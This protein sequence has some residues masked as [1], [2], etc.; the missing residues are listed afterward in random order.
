MNYVKHIAATPME[1]C[2]GTRTTSLW[3]LWAIFSGRA[4]ALAL[5][6]A[7]LIVPLAVHAQSLPAAPTGLTATP[8]D[9]QVALSWANPGD[10]TITGY[11]V[12]I[13][14]G[15]N[16]DPIS[17]SDLIIDSDANTI[18]HT[19]E[20]LT[21]GASYTFAVRAV[22]V[23]G[24]GD[25]A[26]VTATPLFAA[27]R[28]LGAANG[29]KQVT[30]SWDNPNNSSISGYEV[31]IANGDYSTISG[32]DA[33]TVEHIVTGLANDT[34]YTLY[35]RAV[36]G[37]AA[38]VWATPTVT[39]DTVPAATTGLTAT[40][41][42]GQVTLIW[43]DPG[44][45][46]ITGYQYSL[47]G[48]TRF[49]VAYHRNVIIDNVA[50]TISHIVRGLTGGTAYSFA[51]RAVNEAGTGAWSDPPVSETPLFKAP[52]NLGAT[53]GDSQVM[54]RWDEADNDNISVYQVSSNGGSSYDSI[55]GSDAT[56]D[57]HTVT[58]LANLT[59]YTFAVRA[60]NSV[61]GVAAMVSATPRVTNVAVPAAPTNLEA[62]A[63]DMKAELTWDDPGNSSISGY[64]LSIDGGANYSDI[65][66]SNDETVKYEVTGLTNWTTYYFALRAVTEG[67]TGAP[68]T[69]SA[70]PGYKPTSAPGSFT[71]NPLHERVELSWT[72]PA[73]GTPI[74]GYKLGK[75]L[76]IETEWSNLGHTPGWLYH[77]ALRLNNHRTYDFSVWAYNQFGN[78]PAST[79]TTIR[80]VGKVPEQPT[81]FIVKRV[82]DAEVEFEW[83]TPAD[84][85]EN[86]RGYRLSLFEGADHYYIDARDDTI[87]TVRT[88]INGTEYNFSLQAENSAGYSVPTGRTGPKTPLFTAPTGLE[89]SAGAGQVT[90]SWTNAAMIRH[91]LR[92]GTFSG[93]EVSSDGGA[94]YSLIDDS[95]DYNDDFGSGYFATTTSH[96][97]ENLTGGTQYTFAVR[98]VNGVSSATAT[99]TPRFAAP[100]NLS[101]TVGNGQ[102][103]LQWDD[104]GNSNISGYQVSS[105]AGTN[106]SPIS[107]SDDETTEYTV[108]G[109]ANDTAYTFAVRA[110]NAS[111][112]GAAATVSATPTVASVEEVPDAPTN[113]QASPADGRVTLSWTD[114]CISSISGY[115]VSSD[116]GTSYSLIDG[117][118]T[119][120]TS[121]TVTGLTNGTS[122][123]FKVRARNEVGTGEPATATATPLIAAPTSFEAAVGYGQVTLSWTD[124]VNPDINRYQVSI[125]GGTSYR[126]ILRSGA[127]TTEHTVTG[128][129]GGA[130]YS[131]AVRA[132]NGESSALVTA[133]PLFVEPPGLQLFAGEGQMT[134]TWLDPGNNNISGYEFSSDGTEFTRIVGSNASTTSHTVTE[135]ENGTVYI[136]WL[137]AVNTSVTGAASE[138]TSRTPRF[139]WPMNLGATV[140]DGQVTL[141][142]DDPD[143]TDISGYEVVSSAE[144]IRIDVAVFEHIDGSS[145]TTV[146]HTVTDLTNDTDL[147]NGTEYFFAVRAVNGR[148]AFVSATPMVT[149]VEDVPEALTMRE[150]T[151][152][153]GQVTLSWDD[154]GDSSISGYQVSRIGWA[155]FRSVGVPAGDTSYTE[156]DLTNGTSYTFL[157]RAVNERG[158]GEPAVAPATTP[159]FAAL[160]GL[161]AAAGYGQ[162][163]L[164]WTNPDNGNISRYELSIDGGI[165]YSLILGSGV[166][167]TSHTV[168]GLTGGTQYTFAVRALNGESSA[169][170]T[171]TPL[172]AAPANLG[173][174][175]GYEQVTL[176]WDDPGNDNISG[177]ELS[178]DGGTN[179]NLISGSDANTT[180]HTVD[181]LNNGT[182][183]TFAVRAVNASGKGA[184]AL[185]SATLTVPAA[186]TSLQ[187]TAGDGQVELSWNDPGNDNIS[188]YQV[189]SDGGTIY[190]PISDSDD[191]TTDY[192]ETGLTNGTEY[193]FKVRA[194]NEVGTGE[195][196]TATAKP[197]IAAPTGLQAAAGYGQVTL[198]WTDPENSS[199]SDY[200]VSSDGGTIYSP[201]SDSDDETTDHTVADL[202]GGAEYCFV[203]RARN[204]ESAALVRA[205]PLFTAPTNLSATVGN[206]QVTLRWDE[207]GNDNISSYQVSRDEGDYIEISGSNAST[208]S[209]IVDD[210]ANGTEY[211]FA[212]RARNASLTGAA[213]T[214]SAKPL[215]A[216]PANLGAT[217]G[218]GQVTLSW[219]DPQDADISGYQ[220][221]RDE[222]DYIEISG[223]DAATISHTVTGLTNGTEYTFAVRAVNGRAATASATP[224]PVPAAPAGLSAAPGDG[225]VALSWTDPD[226]SSI[227]GYELST[228]EGDY[229]EI[230][231]SD[232]E[233]TD[234]TVT[235]L[236]NGTAYTFRV[237]AVNASGKGAASDAVSA[238]PLAVPEAPA[239]LTATP[240]D[241]QVA[242]SW[243]DP[244]NSSISGY[245]LSTDGG[246]YIEISGSDDETTDY[247]VTGLTNGTSYT[248]AV[249]AVNAS[250][251]GAASA[252]VSATP[253]FAAPTNLGAKV[254]DGQVELSWTDPGNSSISG[255]EVSSELSS[256]D[257]ED[258]TYSLIVSSNAST[259]DH[260]VTGLTN[261]EPYTFWLRAVNGAAAWVSATPTVTNVELPAAP[262]NLQA[263][264]G[265]GQVTLS[266]ED[267]GNPTITG[268][269]VSSDGGSSYSLIVPS[270][271]TTIDHTVAGLTNG[272]KYTFG[273]R[274]V[275]VG[276]TGEPALV[277][278]TPLAPL[279]VPAAPAGLTAT[280]GDGQVTLRWMDP[281]NSS[282]SGY[283]VSSDD[284]RSYSPISGSGAST[285]SHTVDNLTNGTKY[286]FGVRAVNVSGTGA[287]ATVTAT[288]RAVLVVSFGAA[289][290]TATEGGTDAAVTVSLNQE[291]ERKVTVPLLTVPPSGDF[292][293]SATSLDFEAG[294]SKKT[295][296]VTAREDPDLDDETVRLEFGTLPADVTEG[297]LTTTTVTLVDDD[298]DEIRP[299]VQ[300]QMEASA[301]VGGA[302]AVTITFSEAVTGFEQSEITV[303]NGSVTGF[304]GSGTSYTAEITPSESGEVTVEIG[305]DVAED[306]AG[307]GNEAAE[308][309]VI[310]ADLTRPEVEITS[311]AL[312]PVG[313][314]FEVT[315]TF[316]EQVQ[317]FDLDDFH[318]TNGTASAFTSVSVQVYMATITPSESGDVTV[319]V[320]ADAAQDAAG[321]GNEAA[322]SFSIEADLTRPEMEITRDETGPVA[323]AFA[324]TITFSEEVTGFEVS[325]IEV[326]NGTVVDF[327]EVSPSE[328]QATIKPTVAGPPVVLVV[329]EDVATDEAGNGNEAA[330]PFEAETAVEVSYAADSYTATEGG[331]AVTVTV[332]LSQ[333]VDGELSIPI[334]VSRPETTELNDFTVEALEGWDA[335]EGAGTLTFTPGA[336][337]LN[338]RI[339]ANHDGD[340]DDETVKLEF[341]ELPE[342]AIAG[343]PAVATV[344]LEDKGL[345]ELQVSFAQAVYEVKEGQGVDIEM[346]VS[347]AADRRV[348]VPLVVVLQGGTRPED[349]SGVPSSVVFEEGQSEG[350]ISV[351]LLADEVNDPGEGIVL[352]LG[353]LPE[354]VIAGDHSSTE[355]H[356]IQ[357]RTAEQ[358]SQSLEVMLAVVAR[359]MGESA[360]TAIESRFERYRQ[361]SR[362]EQPGEAMLASNTETLERMGAGAAASSQSGPDPGRAESPRVTSEQLDAATI[363]SSGD[364]GRPERGAT[365]SWL[366]NFSLGSLVGSAPSGQTP[367]GISS[368]YGLGP[369]VG[370]MAQDPLWVS[371]TEEPPLRPGSTDLSETSNQEFNMSGVSFEMALAEIEQGNSKS[372][373][374]VL[375]GQGDLQYF[376]GELTRIGMNYRGGLDAA[377]LGLDLYADEQ[378]LA[379]LSLMRSWGN[380]D[381]TDDGVDGVL[382][383]RMNT[384]HP[385]LYWQPN[386]RW[387][388]WGI[389]GMGG[390]QVEVI[391]PG[392][393]H[394]FDA[395]FK[396]FSAGVRSALKI[397]DNHELGLNADAFT[398]Q[399]GTDA[400]E[401]IAQLRGRA[402]RARLMLDWLY[403][404]VLPAGQSLS[405]KLEAGGRFDGGDANRGSGL[406][407]GFRLGLLDV[408]SGLDVALHG[409]ALLAHESDYQDRGVG[410]QASWDPGEKQRGLR[411]SL[412]SS[413]GRDGGGRT[414][415]WDN[416]DAVTHSAG[417]GTLWL[418]SQYQ[419]ESEVAYAGIKA[420]GLPGV[421]TPYSRLR[422]TGQGRELGL[423][424]M[425]TP[426]ARTGQPV[427]PA[428]IELEG[429][430]RESRAGPSELAIMLHVSIPFGGSRAIAP[431]LKHVSARRVTAAELPAEPVNAPHQD[432]SPLPEP[433][434]AEPMRG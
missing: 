289:R 171:A 233:T 407:T 208:T 336:T 142:W 123:T 74:N 190:S 367:S 45:T 253:L 138:A 383:S 372:W 141:R 409:R 259:I 175:I 106:Y 14:G 80:P 76:S 12:S 349:Y 317:G 393:K 347:P 338:W 207:P 83:D 37:A 366:R 129:T 172:F 241:G 415:L 245:E 221:S 340:G 394:N 109:L 283:E 93:L 174:T 385:Y 131:F 147:T 20:N 344:M 53:V 108:T 41:G 204:G 15:T 184:S 16:Y 234:Y 251:T 18:S 230:S 57:E 284:G 374:P 291:A 68:A 255:Y 50:N 269:H 189:S 179:Y 379:G 301:P 162:V 426:S 199:I 88:L 61:T 77:T 323:G 113:L 364:L 329:P 139:T 114:P 333:A 410:I 202:T 104:P 268:Y 81:G 371:A 356:F 89:A 240:G 359:S 354:A 206:G 368:A 82:G 159:L 290:Y 432:G 166:N 307:N 29:D 321:N 25:P 376:N 429:Q 375:W 40:P 4:A 331:D 110:L 60:V 299:T 294:D 163:T 158:T 205:T 96:T 362:M 124:P 151:V 399:L 10:T 346:T 398:A 135:L 247:T 293:L 414:T 424:S 292:A 265:D 194:R 97:V 63:G 58:G 227:T 137:R 118:G 288:P 327:I 145:A 232:D 70:H 224:A 278:A 71:G 165:S 348:E 44:D 257:D 421:L 1:A 24:N 231:G 49:R 150:P 264:P 36:N 239:G 275:N 281:G 191:E 220:V 182:S 276:G 31:R 308:S 226:N 330:E 128:L 185:V 32:S 47:D 201:I 316:S 51:V 225:Q 144:R 387:S 211:T 388:V 21:G 119:A 122:Y 397:R 213:A 363:R 417:M 404:K 87:Y 192:T 73:D 246:D 306:A 157:V 312:G 143:N 39:S 352:S 235:G 243:T 274:A 418:D 328:Y 27:P 341:G 155:G 169:T 78:G 8:G 35:V 183:Y 405:L 200:Q 389:G 102:V 390:G 62:V 411:A 168:D 125:D 400:L 19:V 302:F 180:S 434:T 386:P 216:A 270:N 72:A 309:L 90:L 391:E 320:A 384:F 112:N 326:T 267:P 396:M 380:M 54:L 277:S 215:F 79:L 325:E 358:F 11:Q 56:T 177:Y 127:N 314:A 403:D 229:I 117:S 105:D 130:K 160:T 152:G 217:I 303:T 5:A 34:S 272:T 65:S 181:N 23:S 146:E 273:V 250:G 30:L 406:E 33:T 337:E 186:P 132:R 167:T 422:W 339:A 84:K 86:L 355:V 263:S 38:F 198:S 134:L 350:T 313:G 28:H 295:L 136:F 351:E 203:V 164:S 103:T 369:S 48:G 75:K 298:K 3:R 69:V 115:E 95:D 322:E 212:V 111:L 279:A 218:D 256:E 296:T 197:L 188:G 133:T 271:A 94:S 43:D 345:V 357:Y 260:T 91:S 413:W 219:D 395:D 153:D 427:L 315:I 59:S 237:R 196:A 228:D 2:L 343:E 7:L 342:I 416:A 280:P 266:W 98:V 319:A 248:F 377:H 6:A 140:G 170:V 419:M 318:V 425:W 238:T 431:S 360:Q 209:H 101:A 176:S 148:A 305:A 178:T 430:R 401:D 85:Y 126:P 381:Y 262:S 285:T 195:P 210:L 420:P 187:A 378:M 365:Q 370:G 310:E 149:S 423:G 244:G 22:N 408:N 154:P 9:S 120:T 121:H 223:S 222:G 236:T 26:T 373:A 382:D 297:S 193:T 412:A 100:A 249:Q 334:R 392:R 161:Q 258:R 252:A 92:R 287:A 67:G 335:Q 107:S 261:D 402:H 214:M 173:A 304:S 13:D 46:T 99:A 332:K 300:I 282:I 433:A 52:R 311:D 242:L 17:G 156:T 42:G 64:Q 353:E 66:G 428:T 286:T 324:V 254:G 55:S 116:G 361:W